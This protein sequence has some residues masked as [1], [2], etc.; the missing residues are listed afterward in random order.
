MFENIIQM[1]KKPVT[2]MLQ[3]AREE[4][5]KKGA[6]KTLILSVIL[7]MLSVISTLINI[8][9]SISEKSYSYEEST[10]SQLWEKMKDAE[11]FSSFF[12][13]VLIYAIVIAVIALI[14]FVIAKFLK[15]EK[16]YSETL[17]MTNNTFVL[18]TIGAIINL[19]I[20]LIYA[21]LGV[22][23]SFMIYIY[24]GLS[25]INT[26]RESLEMV[27]VNKLVLIST[28][29]I[30][31]TVILII[32]LFMILNDISFK[33]IGSITNLSMDSL[34]SYSDFLDY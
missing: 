12:K 28:G 23:V 7:S 8:I 15:K 1:A 11:L 26:Y 33:D 29:V 2:N 34:D 22:L 6:I 24:A 30:M 18:I 10:S 32:A 14:L 16:E 5:L 4:D 9:K 21:P 19:I 13:Q 25:L 31:V 20:S 27:D 3:K 17:S